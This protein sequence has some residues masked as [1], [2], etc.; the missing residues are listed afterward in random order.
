MEDDLTLS[1]AVALCILYQKGYGLRMGNLIACSVK[2]K[3][4]ELKISTFCLELQFSYC[5]FFP[6]CYLQ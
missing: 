3:R 4:I 2:L 5:F 6:E 1:A